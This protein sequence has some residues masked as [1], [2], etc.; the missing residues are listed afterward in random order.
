MI[1]DVSGVLLRA[2]QSLDLGVSAS[3]SVFYLCVSW[4]AVVRS[5]WRKSFTASW[6]VESVMVLGLG[7]D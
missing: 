6:A 2:L 4:E 5:A 1:C 3:A 7:S